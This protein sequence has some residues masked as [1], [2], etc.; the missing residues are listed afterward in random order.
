[1]YPNSGDGKPWKK[2][3]STGSYKAAA[4]RYAGADGRER[5]RREV[6]NSRSL[7]YEPP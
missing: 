2:T 4:A 7:Q 1:M 3:D 6:E 5:V